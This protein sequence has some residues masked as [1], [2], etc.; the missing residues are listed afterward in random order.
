MRIQGI[1]A[2]LFAVSLLTSAT[3][4]HAELVDNLR[5]YWSFEN[6]LAD[7]AHGMTGS[8][9]TVA[10]DGAFGGTNAGYGTGKF[11]SALDTNTSATSGVNGT[12]YVDVTSSA[13]T[14]L[15]G[16]A[17]LSVS[18][19][20]RRNGAGAVDFETVYSHGDGSF[21][22]R[23]GRNNAISSYSAFINNP[24][25]V[26]ATG[27]DIFDGEWHHLVTTYDNDGGTDNGS[28]WVDGVEFTATL[29]SRAS[30]HYDA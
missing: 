5:S 2:A 3:T 30:A 20:V 27:A 17:D 4:C 15:S 25:T 23:F 1:A 7:Q 12:G 29:A 24:V 14:K 11:G 18:V 13:D 26:P 6:D 28:I 16:P 10:D 21:E 9:S 22:Y 19:W 8:G